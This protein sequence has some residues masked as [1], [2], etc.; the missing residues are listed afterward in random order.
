MNENQKQKSLIFACPVTKCIGV[1]KLIFFKY[2]LRHKEA[3]RK[4]L[5]NS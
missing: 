2:A 4:L 3:N 5:K 1:L